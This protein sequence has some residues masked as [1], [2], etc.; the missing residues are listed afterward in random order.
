MARLI[1]ER[2]KNN[3][4]LEL[5]YQFIMQALPDYIYAV[6]EPEFEV[7]DGEKLTCDTMLLIPHVGCVIL[8]VISAKNLEIRKGD[9]ILSYGDSGYSPKAGAQPWR[10]ARLRAIRRYFKKKYNFTLCIREFDCYPFVELP[11][12]TEAPPILDRSLWS[13]DFRDEYHFLSKVFSMILDS[14]ARENDPVIYDDLTDE[15]ARQLFYSWEKELPPR[16]RPDRPPMIFLSHSSKDQNRAIEIQQEL[17]SRG[18]F[19]WRAPEDV[20]MGDDYY[21][22]EM[23]AIENCDLFLLLLSTASMYNDQKGNIRV[24]FEAAVRLN[25]KI[26]PVFIEECEKSPY[27]REHLSR[28][29]HRSLTADRKGV[30]DEIVKIASDYRSQ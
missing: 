20:G 23:S 4:A 17:E 27:Y 2:P 26:L 21:P 15:R 7:D 28:C 1:G 9:L 14:L 22:E 25:K 18:V 11:G 3:L 5:L 24:E 16:E 12:G 19:V 29:Q 6:F 8:D 13:E 30:Y 10:K